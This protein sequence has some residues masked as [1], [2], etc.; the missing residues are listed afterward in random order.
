MVSTPNEPPVL[1]E[2]AGPV[3]FLTLNRPQARNA[4]NDEMREMLRGE[5]DRLSADED[6]RVVVLTGAGSAFCAG[7]DIKSMRDRLEQPPDEVA[8][9]GWQRQQRTGAMIATLTGSLQITIAAVNGAASGLGMDLALA[10]DFVVAAPE[11]QFIAS[12]VSRGL[13]PDG[14][15]MYSLPRRVGLPLAKELIFSGRAV[16]AEEALQIRLADR[17]AAP[18]GLRDEVLALA[19][20]FTGNSRSAIAL[21]KSIVS[22]TFESSFELI[23]AQGRSAQAISYTTADHRAAVDRFVQR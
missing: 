20:Q 18:G 17:V 22:R 6:V 10:C 14:G 9:R 7:G 12:F 23:S 2:I 4:I 1:C 19:E 15:G 8:I 3:A 13:V 21:M 11:A 5:L 16:G